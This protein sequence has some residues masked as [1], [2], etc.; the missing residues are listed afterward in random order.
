MAALI[1]RLK[2][3]PDRLRQRRRRRPARHRDA[4][5]RSAEPQPLPGRRDRV[6]VL[7]PRPGWPA[8]AAI[9]KTLVSSSMIDRV[10]ASLGRRLRRGAGGLQVV[11]DGL[12]DGSIG[13][14][15]EE[16]AGASFLRRDGSG[17]DHRQ[18]RPDAGPAGRR[19]HRRDRAG[20]RRAVPRAGGALRRS[21]RT[22]AIDAP[23]TP[24]EKAV[25]GAC[26]P[27][28]CAPPSSPVSRSSPS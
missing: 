3:V 15:G 9:G 28:R 5:R 4:G 2:D 13:F 10:A 8:D 24:S 11:R 26:P 14:G 27:S 6:P 12:V 7:A 21:R 18:G 20:P 16:S 17:V 22:R 1:G 23:A 19:D 25:L